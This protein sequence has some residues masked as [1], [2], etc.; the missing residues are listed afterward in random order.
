LKIVIVQSVVEIF[1][2]SGDEVTVLGGR[3][4]ADVIDY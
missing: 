4:K 1:K 2:G 3:D